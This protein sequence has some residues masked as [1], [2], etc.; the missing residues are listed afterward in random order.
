[1]KKE[2]KKTCTK[3]LLTNTTAVQRESRLD[4]YVS[5]FYK[6]VLCSFHWT[7]MLNVLLTKAGKISLNGLYLITRV[8]EI[9]LVDSTDLWV[10]SQGHSGKKD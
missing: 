6:S 9:G 4:I 8:Q 5:D 7:R 1:M 10:H 3:N 2:K